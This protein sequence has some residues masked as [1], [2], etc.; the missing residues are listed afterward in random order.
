[1]TDLDTLR[2]RVEGLL[3]DAGN[4]D[5]T[6]EELDEAVRLA[7]APLSTLL[8][9]RAV[10]T[11]D[12]VDGQ[13]E[14]DL[15]AVSGLLAVVEVWYPY[16]AGDARFGRPHPVRW[17]MLDEATLYL[18]VGLQPDAAYQVRVFYDRVHTLAGLDAATQTTL[19]AQEQ[20]VLVL[21]AAGYAAL[22]RG[23][24]S[25]GQVNLGP[26]T[27]ARYAAWGEARLKAFE[28]Q[29]H[30]LTASRHGGDDARVGPWPTDG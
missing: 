25:I 24:A 18:D 8:P 22:A 16:L 2:D 17:R 12:A 1:M 27:P 28:Q 5:W 14:Y 21:G 11:L 6:A 30:A 19:N 10:T 15:S 20:A 3:Q 23:R 7:L 9:A 26:D 29:V 4:E 13:F